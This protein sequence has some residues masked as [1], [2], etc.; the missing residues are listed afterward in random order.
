MNKNKALH[1]VDVYLNNVGIDIQNAAVSPETKK[2]VAHI[3]QET[4]NAMAAIID[5]LTE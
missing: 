4:A 3:T 5:A 1:C 2:L